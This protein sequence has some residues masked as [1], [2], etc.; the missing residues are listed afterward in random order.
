MLILLIHDKTQDN[1]EQLPGRDTYPLSTL[2][3]V[4]AALVEAGVPVLNVLPAF[5]QARLSGQQLYWRDDTHWRPEA[6]AIA[7]E[8]S[9]ALIQDYLN[10]DT[11]K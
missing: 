3:A 2:Y 1:R 8:M 4:E 6:M 11:R 10:N 5:Q 7:A 9:A